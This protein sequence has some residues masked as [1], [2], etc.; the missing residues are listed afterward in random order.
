[1]AA[2]VVATDSLYK[3]MELIHINDYDK[4]LKEI[5]KQGIS[6]TF[7]PSRFGK[8]RALGQDDKGNWLSPTFEEVNSRP[9]K[10]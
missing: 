8:W 2:Q 5:K 10:K 9:R 6:I 1:M 4:W 3:I 7:I